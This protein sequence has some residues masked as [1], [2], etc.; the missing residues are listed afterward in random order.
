MTAVFNLCAVTY[1]RL[2]AI[3]LPMETRLTIFSCKIVMACAWVG[4][5]TLAV[6]L[7]VYRTYKVSRRQ[8]FLSAILQ[9]VKMGSIV[10]TGKGMEKLCG[11]F[12]HGKHNRIAHIL[13]CSYRYDRMVS[14]LCND[15]LLF[16]NIL[17]GKL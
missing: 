15:N 9:T 13:A 16:G 2:T 3:V 14:T 11:N 8:Y 5:F 7:A 1:E 10:S 17:E 6:P 12:L 4:G